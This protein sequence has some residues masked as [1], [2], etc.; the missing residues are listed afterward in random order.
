[1][2]AT[3]FVIG[4][5][6]QL[7]AHGIVWTGV[8]ARA[9]ARQGA[10]VRIVMY[11]GVLP[12]LTAPAALGSLFVSTAAFAR[13]LMYL[14]KY[15][16]VMA[17]ADLAEILSSGGVVPDRS[18]VVTIDDGYRNTI[19]AALPVLEAMRVPAT[20][21]VPAALA[22]G[23]GILWF[24]GLRLLVCWSLERRTVVDVG[25]GVILDGRRS[26]G[27]EA[28]FLEASAAIHAL[29]SAAGVEVKATVHARCAE[30]GLTERHSE[31]H[32]AGWD[33]WRRAIRQGLLHVGSH[34][35]AHGDLTQMTGEE[36]V[37]DLTAS[38]QRIEQEL[39]TRC[40]SLAYPYGHVNAHVVRSAACAGYTCAVTTEPGLSGA[41]HPPLL[42]HRTMAGDKGSQAIFE[43]RVSGA[44][45]PGRGVDVCACE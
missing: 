41:R 27:A 1:V 2:H 38:R 29:P 3:D 31:F 42:L 37:Q 26:I 14:R 6:R 35:L 40:L 39:G 43:A 36:Q 22:G 19:A 18:A 20:V 44:W 5:A 32:L 33:E 30:A 8:A 17:L 34:A 12:Q 7:L 11:H 9:R 10:R 24:D 4:S 45:P 25:S 21:F 13:Q 23:P 15:F 16:H 28:I